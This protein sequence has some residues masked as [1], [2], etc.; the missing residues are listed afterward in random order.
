M[1]ELYSFGFFSESL[2]SDQIEVLG[3]FDTKDI[4]NRQKH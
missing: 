2:R 3:T 4:V 1:A